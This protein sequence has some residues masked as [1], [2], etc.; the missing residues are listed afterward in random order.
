MT[1]GSVIFLLVFCAIASFLLYGLWKVENDRYEFRKKHGVDP[2]YYSCVTKGDEF[3]SH[4]D[5]CDAEIA[6]YP[7]QYEA[8]MKLKENDPTNKDQ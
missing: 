4:T 2:K 5:W 7:E 6:L 8:E 1:I 3:C